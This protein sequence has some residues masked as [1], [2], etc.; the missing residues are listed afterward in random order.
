MNY[1]WRCV[2]VIRR[3]DADVDVRPAL[4]CA[5]NHSEIK[6][7]FAHMNWVFWNAEAD[8]A[9]GSV[10]YIQAIS[11]SFGGEPNIAWAIED[12]M[13]D[14]PQICEQMEDPAT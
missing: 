5:A 3:I 1:Q 7:A 11:R 10:R 9:I 2:S 4:C 8:L 12:G 13:R 6:D 14:A